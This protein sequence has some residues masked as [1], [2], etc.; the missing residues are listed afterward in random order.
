M[1][2]AD[3]V[4]ADAVRFLAALAPD[5][6]LTF[7]TFDDGKSKRRE[8]SRI[9]HGSYGQQAGML[10]GLNG[11]GAGVFVMVNRGDGNGRKEENVTA[12][13]AV[14]LDLDGAPLAPVM[15]APIR[16]PIV[17]ESSPGKHHAYWPVA[18][19]PLADFRRAQQTLAERYGGDP[20]VCDVARVMRLP[21]YVH[22]K[23]APHT[24][25]LLHC[26][27]V[28]PWRWPE[29]AE[30]LGLPQG[31]KCAA[32]DDAGTYGKSG[33][34]DALYK[35]ACGLRAQGLDHA[36]AL[37]RVIVT[38][39]G[40]CRPPLDAD[41]VA[42][43]VASAWQG[44]SQGYAKLPHSLLDNAAYRALPHTGKSAITALVRKYNGS[45][46]GR[47]ALTRTE[48]KGWGLNKNQRTAAL[49]ACEAADLIECTARG[50]SAVPGH[51]AT[52]DLFRL[53]FVP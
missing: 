35:F 11:K 45:N 1:A 10:A 34:N 28:M 39:V 41:E 52:T 22:A 14:F 7:Q 19:M 8:L 3:A 16:P 20:V 2:G 24:S 43:I 23:G 47:L 26:D 53:L 15:A 46:N 25:R 31:R 21:G 9:V 18:G 51:R 5:G 42:G 30:A 12:P 48:A 27:P 37:R 13:R 6:G 49:T 29:L 32:N 4:R 40:K 36:E 17:C 44:R 38:N 50:T 33:R